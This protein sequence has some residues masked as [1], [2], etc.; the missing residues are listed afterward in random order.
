[1]GLKHEAPSS[2]IINAAIEVHRQ[3]GP[4]V[5]ESIYVRALVLELTRRGVDIR[6]QVEVE[7][8]YNRAPFGLHRLDLL[9]SS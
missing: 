1:M 6:S 4:G 3:L 5:I 9:E 7:V 2:G 8:C